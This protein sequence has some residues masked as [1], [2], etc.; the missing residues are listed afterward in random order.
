[1][2]SRVYWHGCPST[3]FAKKIVEE[4]IRPSSEVNPHLY[5]D[6]GELVPQEGR[7]YM[8]DFRTALGYA[9][10]ASV[11]VPRTPFRYMFKID[12]QRLLHDCMPDEDWLGALAFRSVGY[13][14]HDMDF[15]PDDYEI[16]SRIF[17][18]SEGELYWVRS[19]L[20]EVNDAINGDGADLEEMLP[21][22]PEWGDMVRVGN[23]LIGYLTEEQCVR[24]MDQYTVPVAHEGAIQPVA[25]WEFNVK[26][27]DR[28][29]SEADLDRVGKRI[30]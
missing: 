13:T 1:M 21:Q 28:I 29:K 14:L 24:L 17:K 2:K 26:D 23:E 18:I 10:G 6:A 22:F 20:E 4:G 3:E 7:I 9:G 12:G 11:Q 27:L 19:V 25:G 30:L 5:V 15:E 16:F 8:G